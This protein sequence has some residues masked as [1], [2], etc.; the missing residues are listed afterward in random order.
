MLCDLD[1]QRCHAH[2]HKDIQPSVIS[3][4]PRCSTLWYAR[5]PLGLWRSNS[6][7]D[8]LLART[9]TILPRT[10]CLLAVVALPLGHFLVPALTLD[11]DLDPSILATSKKST[12]VPAL[13]LKSA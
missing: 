11:L 5:H 12:K 4:W 2:C 9:R 13:T 6:L 10:V 3:Q 8:K 1:L 7:E